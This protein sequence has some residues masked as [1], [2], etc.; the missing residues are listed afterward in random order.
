[1]VKK[2]LRV[3]VVLMCLLSFASL[4]FAERQEW[5]DPNYKFSNVKRILVNLNIP[6][7]LRNGIADNQTSNIFYNKIKTELISKL[8]AS[9]YTFM[10]YKDVFYN[11]QRETGYNTSQLNK[12]NPQKA[13]QLFMDYIKNNVDVILNANLMIYDVGTQYREGYWQS[14]P[15][16]E[17]SNVY[18]G[19]DVI[20]FATVETQTTQQQYIPGQNVRYAYACVKF[21]M[22]DVS[23]NRA[24]WTRIDDR[25]RADALLRKTD[26]KDLFSRI[27]GTY[28]D[29]FQ[30]KLTAKNK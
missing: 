7:N 6:D 15:V 20:P 14:V 19:L 4:S 27:V 1:M 23:T 2:F 10:T 18:S 29:T 24:I 8:P 28:V 5:V 21:E 22:D 3:I 30:E 16:T 9:Q 26:P 12:E 11:I 17:H 13:K 25:A